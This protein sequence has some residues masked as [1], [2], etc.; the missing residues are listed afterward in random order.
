MI[1]R[2]GLFD[3][4]ALELAGGSYTS[5]SKDLSPHFVMFGQQ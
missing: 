3:S 4:E 1:L 2:Y 5:V